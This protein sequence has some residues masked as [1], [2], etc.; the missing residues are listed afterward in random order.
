MV[1][2]EHSRFWSNFAALEIYAETITLEIH[3]DQDMIVL[4]RYNLK[5]YSM[6]LNKQS[7]HLPR[8]QYLY[9]TALCIITIIGVTIWSKGGWLLRDMVYNL[10]LLPC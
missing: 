2:G 5:R 9:Y 8:E 4:Y 7:P 6:F 1:W 3:S 10:E